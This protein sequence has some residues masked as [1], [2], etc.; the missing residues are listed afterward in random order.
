MN[1]KNDD[2]FCSKLVTQIETVFDLDN[3]EIEL[4]KTDVSKYGVTN[5]PKCHVHEILILSIDGKLFYAKGEDVYLRI[6]SRYALNYKNFLEFALSLFQFDDC[7]IP[8]RSFC[9]LDEPDIAAVNFKRTLVQEQISIIESITDET[10]PS[11]ISNPK[12]RELFVFYLS[13]K[14]RLVTKEGKIYDEVFSHHGRDVIHEVL[15][16]AVGQFLGIPVPCNYFGYKTSQFNLAFTKDTDYTSPN[17]HRYVLS[18]AIY[19]QHPC[20]SLV[21]VLNKKF[22]KL[23]I[24]WGLSLYRDKSNPLNLHFFQKRNSSDSEDFGNL[25]ID[26]CANY[27]DLIRSDFFDQVLGGARDR[28]AYD[29]LLPMGLSGPIFTV[30]FGEILFPELVFNPSDQHYLQQKEA[31]AS[32]LSDYFEKVR[33]LPKD[34]PYRRTIAE[35]VYKM[36]KFDLD[37]IGRFIHAIPEKFLL[38]HFGSDGDCYIT[39]TMIDFLENQFSLIVEQKEL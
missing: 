5:Y 13:R 25:I 26:Q 4:L 32:A 24:I 12:I 6:S 7:S 2:D 27:A 21:D 35:L 39:S 8:E 15:A 18:S 23:N 14:E 16:S 19:D 20:P 17:Y 29:Y 34:N 31:Q 28:K 38:D 37:F 11:T 36:R 30:D 9:F 22:R 1:L 3:P 10:Q 33:D